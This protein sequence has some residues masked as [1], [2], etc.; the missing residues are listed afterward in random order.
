M[1]SSVTDA[2]GVRGKASIVGVAD[3]A[4]PTGKLDRQGRDLEG[5]MVR[6]AL[7]DA[8]LAL[9]DIEIGRAHV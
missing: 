4:S 3:A 9:S 6:E 5:A 8:G 1:K 7:A 2:A